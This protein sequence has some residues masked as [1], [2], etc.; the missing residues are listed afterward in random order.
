MDEILKIFGSD[1]IAKVVP[2]PNKTAISI[3]CFHNGIYDNLYSKPVSHKHFDMFDQFLSA[4]QAVISTQRHSP[5]V[6]SVF[7]NSYIKYIKETDPKVKAEIELELVELQESSGEYLPILPEMFMFT[8][9]AQ[10]DGYCVNMMNGNLY[11]FNNKTG[12]HRGIYL[13]H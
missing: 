1:R 13:W 2:Q 4:K 5:N 8:R 7:W 3:F 6:T 12:I 10:D 9:N 11:Y